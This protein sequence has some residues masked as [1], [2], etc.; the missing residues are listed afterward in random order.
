MQASLMKDTNISKFANE[1]AY[2]WKIWVAMKKKLYE[3]SIWQTRDQ[4]LMTLSLLIK[5]II[6]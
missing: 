3:F 2:R 4:V 5:V 1:F 6:F